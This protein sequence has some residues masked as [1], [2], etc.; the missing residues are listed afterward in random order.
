[1]NKPASLTSIWRDDL[2]LI[3]QAA[4]VAG[5]IA[6]SYFRKDVEVFWKNGGHSP[7]T[8]ADFAANDAIAEI[9]RA[10]RPDY[11]WLSEETDDDARRLNAERLFIIDPIDGTRAFMDGKDFWCVSI[12]VVA[13]G[14]PVAGVLYAPALEQTY[15]ATADG[16]LT[17]NG[18]SFQSAALEARRMKVTGSDEMFAKIPPSAMNR[19]ERMKNVPSLAYRLAMVAD[20]QLDA[21]LVRANSHDWDIAAAHL[22]LTN[23]GGRLE[24]ASGNP[25]AYN[26]PIPRHPVLCGASLAS[27]DMM[28][29]LLRTMGGH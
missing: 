25:P 27:A 22:I 12:A 4:F 24:D 15:L 21:T 10:A 8:V 20:G 11:G 3:G 19:I 2:D 26:R 18:V 23:A 13:A 17:K 28:M 29:P 1:M 7:V 5:E 14:K 9:L 16:V 6:M